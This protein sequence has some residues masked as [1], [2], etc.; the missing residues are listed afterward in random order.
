M[1][2]VRDADKMRL[3]RFFVGKLHLRR[4]PRCTVPRRL[5]SSTAT[6]R[7]VRRPTR[8]CWLWR[9]RRGRTR[10]PYCSGAPTAATRAPV[11][12]AVSLVRAL[13][14]APGDCPAL[15]GGKPVPGGDRRIAGRV[16]VVERGG[17][18]TWAELLSSHSSADQ[19]T[20]LRKCTYSGR[21]LGEEQFVSAMEERFPRKWRRATE[22]MVKIAK[23]A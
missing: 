17:A 21:P 14:F 9:C 1:D 18:A 8:A 16:P 22:S 12:G 10:W 19:I 13:G 2:L 6:T 4:Q 23:T 11:A 15:C 7:A 5:R 20:A 3:A